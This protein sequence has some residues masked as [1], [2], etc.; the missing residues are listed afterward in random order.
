MTLVISGF[1]EQFDCSKEN[2]GKAAELLTAISD[3]EVCDLKWKSY[4][5]SQ[6]FGQGIVYLGAWVTTF[7]AGS[8]FAAYATAAKTMQAALW[9]NNVNKAKQAV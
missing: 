9:L 5:K 1:T 7:C 3:T 2:W 4:S 8:L 6:I